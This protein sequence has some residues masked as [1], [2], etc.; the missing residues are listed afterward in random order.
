MRDSI[1]SLYQQIGGKLT[2]DTIVELFYNKI[3][4]DYRVN[5]FFNSSNQHEQIVA[6]QKLLI[7]LLDDTMSTDAEFTDLLDNFFMAAFARSKRKSFVSGADFAFFGYIIEQDQPST[8]FLSDAHAYLLKFMPDNSHYNVIMEHL[9]TT[10]QQLN[11]NNAI[12]NELLIWAE[13][14]RHPVLGR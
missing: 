6:L 4:N 7:A 11:L 14:G 8:Q 13:R 9:T 1:Q 5:R 3:L 12:A 2:I 10:L